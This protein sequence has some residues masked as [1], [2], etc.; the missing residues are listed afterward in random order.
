[1]TDRATQHPA[2]TRLGDSA[3]AR[4]DAR[5]PAAGHLRT[6]L[7]ATAPSTTPRTGA[8]NGTQ[9]AGATRPCTRAAHS[10]PPPAGHHLDGC[11]VAAREGGAVA[12]QHCKPPGFRP[13]WS[14]MRRPADGV[15]GPRWP[16]EADRQAAQRRTA[17]LSRSTIPSQ[18][19]SSKV[20][21]VTSFLVRVCARLSSRRGDMHE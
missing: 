8:A 21:R 15:A 4:L 17:R 14:A 10:R 11:V 1:M 20:R 2:A 7:I 18:S 5:H 16:T 19:R 3:R 13:H 12:P 9:C 6:F